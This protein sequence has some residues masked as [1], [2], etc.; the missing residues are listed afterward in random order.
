MWL[1]ITFGL[2]VVLLVIFVSYFMGNPGFWR[3][4]RRHPDRALHLFRRDESWLIDTKPPAELRSDY[5][6]PFRLISR[7]GVTHT[8]YAR[9]DRIDASQAAIQRQLTAG[10]PAQG[11][12]SA[13]DSGVDLKALEYQFAGAKFGELVLHHFRRT[14]FESISKSFA[15]TLDLLP[16]PAQQIVESWIDQISSESM[17]EEF[18]RKDCSESLKEIADA[19]RQRL[20]EI[21]IQTTDENVFNM[22][23]LIVLNFV[24]SFHKHHS[25]RIFVEK[26]LA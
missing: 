9:A 15:G 26:A 23:Q 1:Y 17:Q 10:G 20:L 8:L 4:V 3:L 6:G 7:N 14:D 2:A 22:F 19:A 12:G 11:S 21:G 24:Y 5:S 18:W 25:N 16:H 13:N